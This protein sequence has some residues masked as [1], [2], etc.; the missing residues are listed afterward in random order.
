MYDRYARKI[1]LFPEVLFWDLSVKLTPRKQVG[2]FR[3]KKKRKSHDVIL[4]INLIILV[5]WQHGQQ[6]IARLIC[7]GWKSQ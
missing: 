5:L 7:G 4:R 3:R 1:I 6:N 2:P